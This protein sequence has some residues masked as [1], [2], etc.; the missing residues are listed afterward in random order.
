MSKNIILTSAGGDYNTARE[1]MDRL[2]SRTL[3][4]NPLQVSIAVSTNG[5]VYLAVVAELR[6]DKE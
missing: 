1:A 6:D 4:A 2:L 5:Y 3:G